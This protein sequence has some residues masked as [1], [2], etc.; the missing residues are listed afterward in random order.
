MTENIEKM[1]PIIFPNLTKLQ[2]EHPN[3]KNL[4]SE[5][6][7]NSELFELDCDTQILDFE[8]FQIGG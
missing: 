6:L 4:Q 1:V 2:V 5:M 8:A 7:Q 3:P